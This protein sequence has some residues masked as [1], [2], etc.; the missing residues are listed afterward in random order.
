MFVHIP[1]L[2]PFGIFYN[3]LVYFEGIWS[4][5]HRFGML[6]Q[7]K[8]GNSATSFSG[9]KCP[10]SLWQ[11]PM[12]WVPFVA[13]FLNFS[14]NNCY[15]LEKAMLWLNLVHE[16]HKNILCQKDQHFDN[17][18]AILS[19]S[20][21]EPKWPPT[22]KTIPTTK[23]SSHIVVF[24]HCRELSRHRENWHGDLKTMAGLFVWESNRPQQG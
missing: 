7:E 9:R 11:G 6:H 4:I 24:L 17:F 23:Q 20:L 15:S 5:F 21:S 1:I 19:S 18:Y 12:L 8:S 22:T 10:L 14:S 2:W 3:H 16:L 13:V